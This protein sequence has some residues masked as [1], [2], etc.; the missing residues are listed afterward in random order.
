MVVKS[1]EVVKLQLS[2]QQDDPGLHHKSLV[3][4]QYRLSET[5]DKIDVRSRY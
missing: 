5:E 4:S 1:H 3:K 2:D